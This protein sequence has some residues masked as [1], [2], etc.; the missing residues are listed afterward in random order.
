M[1]D[2]VQN[3]HNAHRII[4]QVMYVTHFLLYNT[5]LETRNRS[6]DYHSPKCQ[7]FRNIPLLYPAKRYKR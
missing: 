5:K 3:V 4:D 6:N 7:N 2:I 1:G